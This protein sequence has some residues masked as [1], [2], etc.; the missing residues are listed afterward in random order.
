MK[1]NRKKMIN[2]MQVF[3]FE[4]HDVRTIVKDGEPWWVLKDVCDVLR[5]SNPSVVAERL[6]DD[7]R[8]KVDPKLELGSRSSPQSTSDSMP[9]VSSS[10]LP[11]IKANNPLVFDYEGNNVRTIEI[12]GEPWW[13]LKDVCDVIGWCCK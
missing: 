2:Q 11:S 1:G 7:E 6:D 12:D 13:V 10:M 4:G 3:A 9:A 5:L 8:T